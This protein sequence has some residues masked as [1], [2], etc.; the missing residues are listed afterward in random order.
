M[1]CKWY[2]KWIHPFFSIWEWWFHCTVW[3]VN[4][5]GA[6]W[7]NELRS[8][9]RRTFLEKLNVPLLVKKFPAFCGTWSF[10]TMSTRACYMFLFWDRWI[11]STP[12]HHVSWRSILILFSRSWSGLFPSGFLTKILIFLYSHHFIYCCRNFVCHI[13]K[14]GIARFIVTT[15][16][17]AW[18]LSNQ[19]DTVIIKVRV[20]DSLLFTN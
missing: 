12:S 19:V 6:V 18:M 2:S 17:F 1:L 15:S 11:Q 3:W 10:I 5:Y 16:N 13:F 9:W 20:S 8:P 7:L 14:Q 4:E